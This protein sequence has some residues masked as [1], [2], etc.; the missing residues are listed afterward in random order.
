MAKNVGIQGVLGEL[1]EGI[2]PVDGRIKKDNGSSDIV[3]VSQIV[4]V[5]NINTACY[6]RKTPNHSWAVTVQA[7]R[8]AAHKGMIFAAKILALMGA[9]L[10]EE[11]GLLEQVKEE[12]KSAR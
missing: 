5:V 8:P 1:D 3:D 12:F 7:K 10:A 6:G 9:R 2:L 4:P 11:P